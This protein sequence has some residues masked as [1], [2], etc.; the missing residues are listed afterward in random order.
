[1]IEITRYVKYDDVMRR[2]DD[3]LHVHVAQ[4]YLF[5]WTL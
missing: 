1:M 4:T 2:F 5:D 3:K